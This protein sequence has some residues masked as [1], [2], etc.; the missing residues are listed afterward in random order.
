MYLRNIMSGIFNWF[1]NNRNYDFW[2]AVCTVNHT[3][4]NWYQDH[5]GQIK[6]LIKIYVNLKFEY[7]FSI[8]L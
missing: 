5:M 1:Y 4:V 2:Y 7:S 6:A 8:L 3:S